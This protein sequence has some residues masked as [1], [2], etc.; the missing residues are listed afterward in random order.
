MSWPDP[1]ATALDRAHAIARTYRDALH[2]V[3]PDACLRIDQAAVGVGEGWVCGAT[4][5]DRS[6]TVTEAAHLLGVTERRI[7]QLIHAKLIR[8]S[9]K[10]RDGHVLLLVDVLD[11]RAKRSSARRRSA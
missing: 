6:C 7:R 8:S 5:T 3:A 1:R 11:Y 9:G 4:S 10:A 2:R